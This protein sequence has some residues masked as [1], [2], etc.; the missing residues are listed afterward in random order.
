MCETLSKAAGLYFVLMKE[1]MI[2][3]DQFALANP[4]L[5]IPI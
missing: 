5:V 3:I 4:G 1:L 2:Q